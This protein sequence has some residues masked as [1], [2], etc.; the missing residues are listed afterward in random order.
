MVEKPAI[1]ENALPGIFASAREYLM[2][3]A[4]RNILFMDVMRR[5]GEQYREHLTETVPMS[6]IT[7]SN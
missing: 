7:R 5:R 3:T 4:Q 6:S 1:Q 2:D